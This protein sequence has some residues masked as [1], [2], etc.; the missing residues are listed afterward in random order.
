MPELKWSNSPFEV[1]SYAKTFCEWLDGINLVQH[2]KSASK[3]K[4][5][6][7]DN[8]HEKLVKNTR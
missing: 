2:S 4:D 5:L 6:D 3:N 1:R 7:L 8:S